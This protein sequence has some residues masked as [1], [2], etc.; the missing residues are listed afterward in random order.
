MTVTVEAGLLAGYKVGHTNI[1][2]ISHL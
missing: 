1:V 2:S